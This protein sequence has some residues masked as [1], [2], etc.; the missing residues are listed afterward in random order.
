MGPTPL[1]ATTPRPGGPPPS[2]TSR[3]SSPDKKTRL[4]RHRPAL[5]SCSGCH[6]RRSRDDGSPATGHRCQRRGGVRTANRDDHGESWRAQTTSAS[7]PAAASHR[8]WSST[9]LGCSYTPSIGVTTSAAS[10]VPRNHRARTVRP[11]DVIAAGVPAAAVSWQRFRSS[12]HVPAWPERQRAGIA[13]DD[14]K[15]GG[16]SHLTFVLDRARIS[17]LSTALSEHGRTRPLVVHGRQRCDRC[18]VP[19]C[20]CSVVDCSEHALGH[21][22]G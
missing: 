2:T 22:A 13:M 16:W 21:V 11:A 20:P 6:R 10:R 12:S 8:T 7:K 17:G 19:G 4:P 18:N 1:A 9:L 15:Q 3:R 5:P 14:T